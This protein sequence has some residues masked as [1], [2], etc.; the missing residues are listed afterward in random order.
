MSE[1]ITGFSPIV[2]ED[3]KVLLL[4]TLPGRKSLEKEF[5]YADRGNYFWKFFTEY[6]GVE[7]FPSNIEDAKKILK[8][9]KVALWDVLESGER[10]TESGKRTS[11][12]KFISDGKP[13]DIRAFCKE[14]PNIE[15]IGVL[16]KKAYDMF[17]DFFP[18][19]K[20]ECLLSSSGANARCWNMLNSKI[21]KDCRGW[22]EWSEFLNQSE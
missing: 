10:L 17:C 18:D 13:N 16:G 9:T 5:Y 21:N 7:E 8:L 22:R 20:A 6:T 12:D 2:F 4:G 19:L 11:S 14:H 1:K 15:K 3:S